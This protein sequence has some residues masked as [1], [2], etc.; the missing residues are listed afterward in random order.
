MTERVAYLGALHAGRLGSMQDAR[1]LQRQQL[2]AELLK[3]RERHAQQLEHVR[4][5]GELKESRMAQE[6]AAAL[7]Q[8]AE[9]HAHAL[10]HTAAQ[11]EERAQLRLAEVS[12]TALPSMPAD[13]A[14]TSGKA[15]PHQEY[16]LF[17]PDQSLKH[18]H[19]SKSFT[20]LV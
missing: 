1:L 17:G 19:C 9:E 3:A 7:Q 5:E 10:A 12:A 2:Q 13:H 6:H 11:A 16:P 14:F 18:V 20:A 8:T 15:S 4:Q